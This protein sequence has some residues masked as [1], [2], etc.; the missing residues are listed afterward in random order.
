M[1]RLGTKW[2]S[3]T[4]MWMRSAPAA[5]TSRTSSTSR[6]KSAERIEG[7]IMGSSELQVASPK[8]FYAA[9]WRGNAETRNC[10]NELSLPHRPQAAR[11]RGPRA[12][13]LAR[14]ASERVQLLDS[15]DWHST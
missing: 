12:P 1:L 13:Q 5:S 11:V 4:S 2:P 8:L 14:T 10:A 15:S 3:M 9:A 6:E 7:A